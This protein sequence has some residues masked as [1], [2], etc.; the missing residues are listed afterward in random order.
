LKTDQ[1]HRSHAFTLIEIMAV[2][3]V[4]GLALGL[5]LPN[6]GITQK[7]RLEQEGRDLAALLQ[8]ARQRAIVTGR[9]HRALLDLE[10]GSLHLDWHV[11]EAEAY[12]EMDDGDGFM[13][14]T[15]PEP[16]LEYGP[17]SLSPPEDQV[18]DYFPIPGQFG[19][20][21]WLGGGSF[22]LGVATPEGWIERGS[23]Q[24]VFQSD[25]TTDYAEIV[26]A[27]EW[28]NQ[29]LLE[30]QPLLDLIRIRLNE[31]PE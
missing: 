9:A 20:R 18:R 31:D 26:L 29:V 27:D 5:V 19:D 30:V 4:I 3:V 13:P 28:E 11:S 17:I 25:G 22:F 6:L 8:L 16:D 24:I 12:G 15:L 14:A 23:V 10:E 2:V 21:E 7:S 1:R